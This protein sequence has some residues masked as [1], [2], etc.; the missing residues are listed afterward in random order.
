MDWLSDRVLTAF[1][2]HRAPVI[3]C[4]Q[5]ADG[6]QSVHTEG[7][8][9]QSKG[10]AASDRMAGRGACGKQVDNPRLNDRVPIQIRRHMRSDDRHQSKGQL[11]V[12]ATPHL[13]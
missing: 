11:G 1:G 9:P 5:L 13:E 3:R 4:P 7:L 8:D 10:T 6:E 2:R 12:Q